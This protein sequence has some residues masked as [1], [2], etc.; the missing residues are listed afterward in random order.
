MADLLGKLLRESELFAFSRVNR[1]RGVATQA[2]RIPTGARVLDVSA[3]V[4]RLPTAVLVHSV[5]DAFV[6]AIKRETTALS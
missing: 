2:R 6:T 1:D 5:R 4:M 3:G